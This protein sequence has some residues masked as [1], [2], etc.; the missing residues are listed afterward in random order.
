MS[1]SQRS[2]PHIPSRHAPSSHETLGSEISAPTEGCQTSHLLQASVPPG[3]LGTTPA[4]FLACGVG[5][6]QRGARLLPPG[7]PQSE[8]PVCLSR[9]RCVPPASSTLAGCPPGCS[10]A[11][12]PP[13]A[14]AAQHCEDDQN[15]S[16]QAGRAGARRRAA[17][18][19][20]R[21]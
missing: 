9:G 8:K 3:K 14:P 11:L 10:P 18:L 7:R 12:P 20:L 15:P 21:I 1:P 2:G 4:H 17:W 13:S 19:A 6:A 16:C 5:L